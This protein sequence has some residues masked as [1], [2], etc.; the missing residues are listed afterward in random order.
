M[1]MSK[2]QRE[3]VEECRAYIP[4]SFVAP[5]QLLEGLVIII[6]ILDTV[7]PPKPPKP[8][9]DAELAKIAVDA[10]REVQYGTPAWL[11]LST[12]HSALVARGAK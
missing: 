12:I 8:A 6:D 7:K 4:K 5:T 2:E 10:Y 1:T 3:Y 9:T 11:A